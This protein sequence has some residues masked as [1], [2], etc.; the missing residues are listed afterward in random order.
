MRRAL[1]VFLCCCA[2]WALPAAGAEPCDLFRSMLQPIPH[3]RLVERP[4]FV[5][6]WD[7]VERTGCELVFETR[8]T[9]VPLG[10]P[11]PDFIPR[12]GMD[13]FSRGWRLNPRYQAD[14]PGSSLHAIRHGATLCV[15]HYSQPAHLESHGE[16]VQS[17]TITIT[18][19]CVDEP[20]EHAR[21]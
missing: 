17:D 14:G 15:V 6:M 13:L 18:V 11:I 21:P 16:I 20:R 8:E 2:F 9:L 5:S 19:Q 7:R 3:V 12:R 4:A 1:P 10:V